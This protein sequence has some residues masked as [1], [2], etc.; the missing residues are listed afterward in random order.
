[1]QFIS[2]HHGKLQT[3]ESAGLKVSPTR[4]FATG[5][6]AWDALAPGQ[7]FARGAVHELLFDPRHGPPK[8]AAAL[9][10][11]A[12]AH[13]LPLPRYSVGESR[14]EGGCGAIAFSDAEKEG[15]RAH[16]DSARPLT[17]TLSHGV[18]RERG[19]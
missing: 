16:P 5:L 10:A 17:L 4:A 11:Q 2:C 3:L 15:C 6:A 9:L 12:A 18:P 13:P 19:P 1:M 8:F 7:S 14:G